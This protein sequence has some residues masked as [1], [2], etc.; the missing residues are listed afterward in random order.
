MGTKKFEPD[1]F[2]GFL[3]LLPRSQDGVPLRHVV[4][5]RHDS[6]KTA[7]FVAM[8][9]AAGVGIVFAEADSYPMIADGSGDLFYA[10]CSARPPTSR[11]AIRTRRSIH[12]RRRRAV[13]AAAKARPACR[14]W[15]S[16]SL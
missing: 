11:T 2:R 15:L 7:E 10:R 8:A 1:D 5:P 9:R 13:G 14:R 16:R 4:E 12:G 6:F 3:Q